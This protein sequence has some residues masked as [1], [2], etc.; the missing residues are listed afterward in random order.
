MQARSPVRLVGFDV[1]ANP[2]E[3]GFRLR[4]RIE[5]GGRT[6]EGVE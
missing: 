2:D 4:G 3:A 1:H 5:R 6:E